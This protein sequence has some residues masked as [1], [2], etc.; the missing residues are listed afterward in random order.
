M[1]TY[2]K[3]YEISKT[4]LFTDDDMKEVIEHYKKDCE[5]WHLDPNDRSNFE[6]YMDSEYL[7]DWN[8]YN[9]EYSTSNICDLYDDIQELL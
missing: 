5:E 9:V 4:I 6:N 2:S 7:W 3:S 1:F 8:E